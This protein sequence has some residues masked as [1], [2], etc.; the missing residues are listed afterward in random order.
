MDYLILNF[1][2]IWDNVQIST[3]GKDFKNKKKIILHE[4]KKSRIL[5]NFNKTNKKNKNF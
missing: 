1:K 3:I 5:I 4:S 2:K